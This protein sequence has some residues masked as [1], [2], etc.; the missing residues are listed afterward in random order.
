[1]EIQIY[2]GQNR[3]PRKPLSLESGSSKG[4]TAEEKVNQ[5]Y[6]INILA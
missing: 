2:A 6:K 4:Y 3:S 5:K 1:M